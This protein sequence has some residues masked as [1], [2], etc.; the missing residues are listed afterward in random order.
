MVIISFLMNFLN[1]FVNFILL[2]LLSDIEEFRVVKFFFY[3]VIF[4]VSVIGNV[5]VCI[6]VV[7]YCRMRIIINYFVLNFVVVDLVV[8]CICILFDILV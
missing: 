3:V 1:V 2:F 5:F 4:M 7:R 6:I 8:I